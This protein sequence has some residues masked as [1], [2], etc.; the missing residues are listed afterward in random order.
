MHVVSTLTNHL[1]KK[2]KKKLF[3]KYD[4]TREYIELQNKCTATLMYTKISSIILSPSFSRRH[5]NVKK[6]RFGCICC[7][8]A[9]ALM[10]HSFD[11]Y[12][13]YIYKPWLK[14]RF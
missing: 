4:I 13:N 12:D 5:E 9:N 2:K 14:S 8:L 6:K 3:R 1:Q 10:N 7:S 11:N